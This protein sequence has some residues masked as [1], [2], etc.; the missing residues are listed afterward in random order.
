MKI[1]RIQSEINNMK[2]N[3]RK[4]KLQGNSIEKFVLITVLESSKLKIKTAKNIF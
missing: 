4:K 1:N 3:L 2:K